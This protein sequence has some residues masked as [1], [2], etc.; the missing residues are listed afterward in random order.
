MIEHPLVD[1]H[2]NGASEAMT[3]P[4]IA[5]GEP[6]AED[7]LATALHARQTERLKA[8]LTPAELMSLRGV[9]PDTSDQPRWNAFRHGD[10]RHS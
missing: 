5:Y 6:L 1:S 10:T 2:A 4:V 9:S 3:E 7:A 8:S